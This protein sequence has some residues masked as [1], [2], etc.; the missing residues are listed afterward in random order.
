MFHSKKKYFLKHLGIVL[1]KNKN[2]EW[3]PELVRKKN[4]KVVKNFMKW[5]KSFM[6]S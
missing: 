3:C 6:L 1:E 5:R 4:Q 2:F